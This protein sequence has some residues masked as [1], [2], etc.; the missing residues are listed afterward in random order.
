MRTPK[1]LNKRLSEEAKNE[2]VSLNSF[3]Q[4]L[5][6]YALGFSDNKSHGMTIDLDVLYKGKIR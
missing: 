2:G 1:L 5:I 3:I 4:H 6:S